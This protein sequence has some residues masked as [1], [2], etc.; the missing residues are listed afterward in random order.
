MSNSLELRVTVSIAIVSW[1]QSGGGSRNRLVPADTLSAIF[2][3]SST[4]DESDKVDHECKVPL[5]KV[6]SVL[7]D[8]EMLPVHSA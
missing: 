5:F 1:W 6:L 7:V 3:S 4:I 8:E 2:N